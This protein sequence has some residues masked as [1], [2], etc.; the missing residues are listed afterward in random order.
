M[1]GSQPESLPPCPPYMV[2]LNPEY[3]STKDHI[4]ALLGS[5]P[6]SASTNTMTH[7]PHAVF[8]LLEGT[9]GSGKV[10]TFSSS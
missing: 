6:L 4:T 3:S 8:I 10:G 7:E 5:F 2:N 1:F 9:Q